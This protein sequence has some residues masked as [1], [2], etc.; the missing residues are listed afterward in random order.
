MLTVALV[1]APAVAYFAVGYFLERGRSEPARHD[2]L[3]SSP[4]LAENVAGS[5]ALLFPPAPTPF[6][7]ESSAVPPEIL[8]V[9]AETVRIRVGNDARILSVRKI[10]MPSVQPMA[11]RSV[12]HRDRWTQEGRA[13][14]H[15]S[16]ESVQRRPLPSARTFPGNSPRNIA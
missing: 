5:P 9:I 1:L 7:V 16:H 15:S 6:P 8:A 10:E 12:A 3:P 14:M 11:A 2:S 4:G 13:L